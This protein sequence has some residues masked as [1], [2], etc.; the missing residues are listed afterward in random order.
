M[1]TLDHKYNNEIIPS[2][3]K[4]VWT[5]DEGWIS[6]MVSLSN[7]THFDTLLENCIEKEIQRIK[8]YDDE[9][10]YDDDGTVNPDSMN[11]TRAGCSED[12]QTCE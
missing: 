7:T 12:R 2:N 11:Q 6:K 9:N 10:D 5:F 4:Q 1:K 3:F 8:I